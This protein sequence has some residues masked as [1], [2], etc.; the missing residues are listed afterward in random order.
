MRFPAQLTLIA[1]LVTMTA[2]SQPIRIGL[3][4]LDTSHAPAF[5]HLLNDSTSADHVSGGRVVCAYPGGSKD[6]ES[7]YT[8]VE[9]Y[10]KE[11]QEKW[12]IEIVNEIPTLIQKVDA[13]ILTSLDGRVHLEQVRPV[14]QARKPVFVDKPM[15]A[16]LKDVQEIFR[17]AD[18]YHTP[19]FSASSLRYLDGFYEAV[20]DQSL[21]VIRGC[22]AFSPATMAVGHPDLVYYGI[23]AV[24]M[25][26]TALGPDC[27]EIQRVHQEDTDIVIGRW[28]GGRLGIFRGLR[29]G[30]KDYGATL[31][32]EQGIAQ[33]K[34]G[35]GSAYKNLLIEIMTFFRT[36]QEP[37]PRA[38][39]LSM[40]AFMEA[41]DVSK[42]KPGKWIKIKR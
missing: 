33:F 21:G 23:H 7:S 19:C 4:G 34:M 5:T 2:Y 38:E 13:V 27:E 35:K 42:K 18:Q 29:S 31:Y 36:G 41:A 17:L 32:G 39:T 25:L 11:L 8:R 1:G 26:F 30:A 16:S 3:I 12:H 37:V 6:F 9:G 10:T 14:L 40:F 24:E 20:R 22:D 15:A 28:Q